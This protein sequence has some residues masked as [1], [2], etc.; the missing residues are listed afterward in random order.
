MNS[1]IIAAALLVSASAIQLEGV[2]V[3]VNPVIARPTGVE[4]ANLG[5]HLLVG[6]DEVSVAKKKPAQTVLAQMDADDEHNIPGDFLIQDK[7]YNQET[8]YIQ[9]AMMEIDNE[10][11]HLEV[12]DSDFDESVE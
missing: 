3:H 10:P 2:P 1:K 7:D 8:L 11:G 12:K 4:E 9:M 6:P 5:L